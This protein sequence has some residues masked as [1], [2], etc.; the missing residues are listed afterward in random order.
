MRKVICYK[1]VEGGISLVHPAPEMFDANSKTR[2]L[3]SLSKEA[4]EEE[5]LALVILQSVP[6]GVPYEVKNLEDLPTDRSYRNA[7]ELKDAQIK[8]NMP[9]AKELFLDGVRAKRKPLLE[10]LDV[11]AQRALESKDDKA[12]AE[13][14][15]K[16]QALRDLPQTLP[17][18]NIKTVA[19]LDKLIPKELN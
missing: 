19:E 15:S 3:T 6:E 18:A 16:K 14:V 1:N 4:T 10:A 5:V 9:K 8:I 12:L 7:W 17:L 2:Q 11:E 13:V